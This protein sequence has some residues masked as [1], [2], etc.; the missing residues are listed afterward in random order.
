MLSDKSRDQEGFSSLGGANLGF[1]EA[2]RRE[3]IRNLINN[4]IEKNNEKINVK[5]VFE[6]FTLKY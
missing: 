2:E 6:F 1:N 3:N 5:L 4:E